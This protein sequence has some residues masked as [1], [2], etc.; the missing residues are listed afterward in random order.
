MGFEEDDLQLE[1]E[2]SK[3]SSVV[4]RALLRKCPVCLI[5]DM[6]EVSVPTILSD[7][8]FEKIRQIQPLSYLKED[9]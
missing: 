8:D 1:I 5:G 4:L 2:A 9:L 3:A 6:M 7:H